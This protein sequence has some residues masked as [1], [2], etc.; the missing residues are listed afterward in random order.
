MPSMRV[1]DWPSS[2]RWA[3]ASR[4][5][6]LPPQ[7]T[8]GIDA[9]RRSGEQLALLPG[10][11]PRAE[12]AHRERAPIVAAAPS[13]HQRVAPRR[14][15]ARGAGRRPRRGIACS[16]QVQTHPQ[17]RRRRAP[18]AAPRAAPPAGAAASRAELHL[19]RRLAPLREQRRQPARGGE[20]D[21]A[22]AARVDQESEQ[23]CDVER[24][25]RKRAVAARPAPLPGTASPGRGGK[26][27]R[28]PGIT[29]PPRRPHHRVAPRPPPPPPRARRAA[30]ALRA[31]TRPP[32]AA[33]CAQQGTSMRLRSSGQHEV[34]VLQQR[35]GP[36]RL[37]QR[38]GAARRGRRA[39]R[40]ASGAPPR[41]AP[42]GSR[43]GRR[44]RAPR[45]SPARSAA[46]STPLT[47]VAT[48][49]WRCASRRACRATARR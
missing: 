2:R 6:T 45:R 24:Q 7:R 1:G 25:R 26:K 14:R 17:R 5:P 23:R 8:C 16:G 36:R 48:P 38:E 33:R 47:A 43:A 41:R 12:D 21:A 37:E 35:P 29:S 20:R 40:A 34:A 27:S 3:S 22:G 15:A 18:G 28:A 30:C 32:A 11:A 44:R 31:R 13:R 9:R 4:R 42:A 10:E 19:H 46:A 49:A 39:R